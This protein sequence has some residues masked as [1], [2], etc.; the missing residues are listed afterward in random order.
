[1]IGILCANLSFAQS[2]E[3]K[4]KEINFLTKKLSLN[5]RQIGET[6]QIIQRK[7][8]AFQAIQ[9]YKDSDPKKYAAKIKAIY[10]G[11]LTSI[12]LILD[13]D[14]QREA[15]RLYRIDLRKQ[16]AEMVKK[17]IKA[18]LSPEEASNKY[19]REVLFS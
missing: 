10:E 8:K 11:T 6:T 1:M 7:Y 3:H 14:D 12:Q 9:K 13:N 2:Q 16:K 17:N 18:G 19:Y 4:V 5:D 15:F